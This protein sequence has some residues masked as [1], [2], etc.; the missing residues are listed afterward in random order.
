MKRLTYRKDAK[1]FLVPRDPLRC[2]ENGN[3][4]CKVAKE[5]PHIPTRECSY[6]ALLDTIAD[7]EDIC[8]KYGI[9]S[10]NHLQDVLTYCN[11]VGIINKIL[12]RYAKGEEDEQ[13]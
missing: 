3:A 2:I 9:V 10:M 5:C 8:E 6:M 11:S 4:V 1:V 12:L 13:Y 7:I